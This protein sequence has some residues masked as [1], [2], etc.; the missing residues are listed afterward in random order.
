M[1]LSRAK[2]QGI[3]HTMS[4]YKNCIY[5]VKIII[6]YYLLK[7]ALMKIVDLR[8][9]ILGACQLLFI[10]FA[11]VTYILHAKNNCFYNFYTIRL[12][13]AC[14]YSYTNGDT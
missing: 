6:R 8:S 9:D 14:L 7:L 5:S 13:V 3:I 1:L 11:S 2:G 12:P 4:F 10:S